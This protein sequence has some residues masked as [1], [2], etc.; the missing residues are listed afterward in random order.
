MHIKNDG[1]V[2]VTAWGSIQRKKDPQRY[3]KQRTSWVQDVRPALAFYL[4]LALDSPKH[5]PEGLI[6]YMQA[7]GMLEDAETWEPSDKAL[8]RVRKIYGKATTTMLY[9]HGAIVFRLIA[10]RAARVD[11]A[12]GALVVL[13]PSLLWERVDMMSRLHDETE[14][15]CNRLITWWTDAE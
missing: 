11:M 4:L 6:D 7:A 13:C 12:T 10:K 14:Q 9:R 1:P 2:S 15:R 3:D 5:V 8:Q